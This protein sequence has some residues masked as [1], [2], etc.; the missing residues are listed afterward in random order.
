[1]GLRRRRTKTTKRNYWRA[2]LIGSGNGSGEGEEGRKG[3]SAALLVLSERE[4][5]RER[6]ALG[7]HTRSILLARKQGDV[8]Q[9]E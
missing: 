3:K 8:V 9:I 1:M 2:R 7:Q 6:M 4:R 5:E